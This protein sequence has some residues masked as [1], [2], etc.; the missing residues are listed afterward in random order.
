MILVLDYRAKNF[1]RS[2]YIYVNLLSVAMFT[3]AVKVS[4][5][6]TAFI[7]ACNLN[8]PKKPQC[9]LYLCRTEYLMKIKD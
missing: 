7:C 3:Q 8:C 2:Q 4:G 6:A 9:L 5:S 1:V